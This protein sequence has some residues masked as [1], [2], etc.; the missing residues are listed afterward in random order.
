M[1]VIERRMNLPCS[2]WL[3]CAVTLAC[4]DAA[5]AACFSDTGMLVPHGAVVHPGV[6]A[7][8]HNRA[9]TGVSAG[10]SALRGRGVLPE[11]TSHTWSPSDDPQDDFRLSDGRL[12]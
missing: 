1:V 7:V 5:T 4:V 3:R 10:G 6:G 2:S 12:K 11:E 8:R 9:E